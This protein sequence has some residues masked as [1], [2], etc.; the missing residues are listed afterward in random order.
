MRNLLVI[1]AVI[2]LIAWIIGFVIYHIVSGFIHILLA[3]AVI[4][5]VVRIVKGKNAA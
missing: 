5:I 1:I 2:L 3:L 4:A